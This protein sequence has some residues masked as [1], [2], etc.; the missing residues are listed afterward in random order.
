LVFPRR[1]CAVGDYKQEF[2]GLSLD[3]YLDA[4]AGGIE[5]R[6]F[7]Q[8]LKGRAWDFVDIGRDDTFNA[9]QV[10]RA[11]VSNEEMF[12]LVLQM[13]QMLTTA[14]DGKTR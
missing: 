7:A 5:S 4:M 6:W 11:I 14:A 2:V 1:R 10:F 8:Y 3:Q 9:L 13:E 12:L